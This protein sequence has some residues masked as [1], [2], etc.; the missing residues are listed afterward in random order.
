MTP[1]W[2]CIRA[3][4]LVNATLGSLWETEAMTE[5]ADQITVEGPL[6]PYEW[7]NGPSGVPGNNGVPGYTASAA[8]TQ[9]FVADAALSASSFPTAWLTGTGN[10]GSPAGDGNRDVY[11]G[12]DGVTP[13]RAGA[14]YLGKRAQFAIRPPS[15]GLDY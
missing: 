3:V 2:D 6:A 14:A 8:V 13:T 11:L 9:R 12:A 4:N 5:I 10:V 7:H 15:T 1:V